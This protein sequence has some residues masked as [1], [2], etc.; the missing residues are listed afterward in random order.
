MNVDF[1][2]IDTRNI[3]KK[4]VVAKVFDA[5]LSGKGLA[6][7]Q[8]VRFQPLPIRTAREVFPQAAHPVNF[9][10][11]VMRPVV[12]GVDFRRYASAFLSGWI[13]R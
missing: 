8:M 1:V 11:R 12:N 5:I 4:I 6:R 2:W 7:C 3:I 10:E 13:F 9:I